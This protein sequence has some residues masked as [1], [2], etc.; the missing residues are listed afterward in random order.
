[1][2]SH[3]GGKSAKKERLALQSLREL[4]FYGKLMH[5]AIVR[6]LRRDRE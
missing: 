3:K 1:M 2:A 6:K 5:Y 4:T